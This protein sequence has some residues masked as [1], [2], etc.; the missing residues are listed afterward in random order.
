[1]RR[2]IQHMKRRKI[3]A[4]HIQHCTTLGTQ[5]RSEL[6][7]RSNT[8]CGGANF[9]LHELTRES[10]S[11]YP[12]STSYDLMQDVQI[13]TCLTAYTDE[14]GRTWIL[15]FN[16]VLWFG[17]SIDHSL[18]NPNQIWMT[19]MPVS[20]DP[21][22]RIGSMVLLTKGYSFPSKLTEIQY[23][24]IQEFLLI[25]KLGN[26]PKLIWQVNRNGIISWLD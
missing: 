11:V 25:F 22:M 10:C 3:S 20:D 19:G 13:S 7:N 24:L 6:D 17:S 23:I 15:V 5:S 18:I 26:V 4:S 1:M 9:W 8:S 14:Y 16:E 2:N 21:F 12:F